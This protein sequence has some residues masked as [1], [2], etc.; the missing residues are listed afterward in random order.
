MAAIPRAAT[1]AF[2]SGVLPEA[3]LALGLSGLDALD[4][5]PSASLTLLTAPPETLQDLE[6]RLV[7]HAVAS[8]RDALLAVGDNRLDAYRLLARAR[9]AGLEDAVADGTWLARAFTVHQY[10]AIL[11]ETLPRLARDRPG[12][13]AMATGF[14][15]L[16]H[17]E[18]VRVPEG[19]ILLTR[20]VRRLAAW[21]R[22]R[23][24]P[25]IATIP[26]PRDPRAQ[27]L[28]RLARDLTPH[29]VE[30]EKRFDGLRVRALPSERTTT[31]PFDRVGQ[32]RL[33]AFAGV[34]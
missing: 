25:V 32:A 28:H 1:S 12:A 26:E 2:R 27:A 3:R 14:L 31:L 34:A 5:F 9:K 17:D 23:D 20:T 33:D 4:A 11:E 29:G 13:I 18:D 22:E 19:R 30:V 6:E 8:G 16:F 24:F 7:L 10:V 15:S 21:A